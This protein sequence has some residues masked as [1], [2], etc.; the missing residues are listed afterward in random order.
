[1]ANEV[2][3]HPSGQRWSL[4]AP[5]DPSMAVSRVL[6]M[7][8]PAVDY[9]AGYAVEME[10]AGFLEGI[11]EMGSFS[12][13]GVIKVISDNRKNP[14]GQINAKMVVQMIQKHALLIKE[15]AQQLIDANG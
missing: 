1:M 9:P 8:T 11:M 13:L 2:V 3:D 6:S 5:Y 4:N 15:L 12:E 7:D 14:A 10:A